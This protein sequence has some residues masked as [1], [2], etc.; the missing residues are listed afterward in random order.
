[1]RGTRSQSPWAGPHRTGTRSLSVWYQYGPPSTP[2]SSMK[3][4]EI[5]CSY[6][7]PTRQALVYGI[8]LE[9]SVR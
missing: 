8:Q 1:M 6:A 2:S 9:H 7:I 3:P 4:G 5:I